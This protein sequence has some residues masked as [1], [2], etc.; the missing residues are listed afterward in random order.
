MVL[1]AAKLRLRTAEVPVR[2]Y[3]DR[4]GRL[5]HHKRGGWFSPWLAG[6]INLKS[7]FLYA[8]DFFLKWPGW[9][10]VV[11][12]LVLSASLAPR[13]ATAWRAWG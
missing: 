3:K 4:E 12:G 6:W 7:M 11:L 2:F 10:M 5:S 1:K 13:A 8:P 9:L